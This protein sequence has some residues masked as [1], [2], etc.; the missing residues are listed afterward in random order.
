MNL[1]GLAPGPFMTGVLADRIGLDG[2]L[3]LVPLMALAA[4][5]VFWVGRRNYADGMARLAAQ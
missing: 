2:A 1:L 3:Q 4:A 5:T